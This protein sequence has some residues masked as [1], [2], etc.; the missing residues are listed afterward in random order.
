MR[1]RRT[2]LE[3]DS[4]LN[5]V[6]KSHVAVVLLSLFY[7][8]S[9]LRVQQQTFPVV[10]AQQLLTCIEKPLH[11]LVGPIHARW[12]SASEQY[13]HASKKCLSL[14]HVHGDYSKREHSAEPTHCSTMMPLP[15]QYQLFGIAIISH[16]CRMIHMIS[17]GMILHPTHW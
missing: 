14:L 16:A 9:S 15:W 3:V 4:A 10:L 17:A 2:R 7:C 6:R 1:S 11:H 8:R 13:S 5:P 12:L